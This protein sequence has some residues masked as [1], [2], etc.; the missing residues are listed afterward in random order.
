MK[1]ELQAAAELY[2]SFREKKPKRIGNIKFDLPKA[3]AII[4]H[5]DLIGYR[6]THGKKVVYYKHDFAEGSRPL[7]CVSADG[8]Q[9]LLLGGRFKFTDRGIVDRDAKG[10][11]I[12]NPAHGAPLSNPK[13]REKPTGRYAPDLSRICSC[14]HRLGQHIADAKVS[15]AECTVAGCD[16]LGFRGHAPSV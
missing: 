2:E 7:F 4:G 8:R 9:L 12:E 11:E 10:K 13:S 1:K 3:V 15:E 5:V 14:G 6:T 16:C